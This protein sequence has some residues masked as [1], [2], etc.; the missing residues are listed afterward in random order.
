MAS[1]IEKQIT[2]AQKDIEKYTKA[3][4]RNQERLA[5]WT[6]KL[7]QDANDPEYR[8]EVAVYQDYVE[9]SIRNLAK[10][11][12][13]LAKLTE[14]AEVKAEQQAEADRINQMEDTWWKMTA[15]E[16][17]AEYEAWLKEFK[18]GCLKDGIKI[19]TVNGWMI[20][21]TTAQGKNFTMINNNGF[22]ERSRHCYTLN[23][24][25]E[26]IFTSGDFSTGY[27]YIKK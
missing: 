25:G 13:T 2:K 18:A 24:N 20:G 9:E 5:K 22:T 16:R 26:T 19:D 4:T 7:E 1:M 11:Q 12:A 8:T 17:K 10:A 3:I 14:Q 21:G 15:E 27:T 23:I 6:A